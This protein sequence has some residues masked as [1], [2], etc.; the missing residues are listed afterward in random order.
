ML[1][2]NTRHSHQKTVCDVPFNLACLTWSHVTLCLLCTFKMYFQFFFVPLLFIASAPTEN[3]VPNPQ[4]AA[5]A[6]SQRAKNPFILIKLRCNFHEGTNSKLIN[7]QTQPIQY[8]CLWFRHTEAF[9]ALW[10][11][12]SYLFIFFSRNKRLLLHFAQ[13]V[14]FYASFF[15]FVAISAKLL[16]RRR[17]GRWAFRS[18]QLTSKVPSSVVQLGMAFSRKNPYGIDCSFATP[19]RWP[20]IIYEEFL[21]YKRVVENKYSDKPELGKNWKNANWPAAVILVLKVMP[22]H[23]R[24]QTSCNFSI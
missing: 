2:R 10:H 3:N 7:N 5:V 14:S 20:D 4:T 21:Q 11:D 13:R 19:S 22:Q 1:N 23:K 16:H 12:K 9:V 6:A 15:F 17:S 8:L 18:E 24:V